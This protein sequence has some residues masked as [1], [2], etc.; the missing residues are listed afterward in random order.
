MSMESTASEFL[1]AKIEAL[2]SEEEYLK[3]VRAGLRDT[4]LRDTLEYQ[5]FQR[6]VGPMILKM[7]DNTDTVLKRERTLIADD[8]DDALEKR[9]RIEGPSTDELLERAYRDAVMQ[10]VIAAPGKQVS[11][12]LAVDMLDSKDF[13]V[14]IV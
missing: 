4:H 6:Q 10:R 13:Q 7:R 9:Q 14:V 8:L 12:I 1:D 5:E 2:Q 11:Q 3:Q